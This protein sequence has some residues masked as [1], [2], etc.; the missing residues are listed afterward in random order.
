MKVSCME[1]KNTIQK[2][3]VQQEAEGVHRMDLEEIDDRLSQEMAE[4]EA[5]LE[6][7]AVHP[8]A[9]HWSAT[10]LGE[11]DIVREDKI[12]VKLPPAVEEEVSLC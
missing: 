5:R 6:D 10:K 9:H 7:A 12:Q 4:L 1:H 11:R 8:V 3:E 2:A